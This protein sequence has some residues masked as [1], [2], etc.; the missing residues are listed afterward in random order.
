MRIAAL[1]GMA[2]D[3]SLAQSSSGG[4]GS[5]V[6]SLPKSW[7]TG[8]TLQDV[9][10]SLWFRRPRCVH[11]AD[12][13]GLL[14]CSQRSAHSARSTTSASPWPQEGSP[15][16]DSSIDTVPCPTGT[17]C[18]AGEGTF[19]PCTFWPVEALTRDGRTDPARLEDALVSCSGRCWA[20]PTT[21]ASTPRRRGP[22]ARPW[23]TSPGRSPTWPGSELP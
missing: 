10:T 12:A 11:A 14:H 1:V 23:R 15:P 4:R 8:G 5:A 22:A 6:R 20:T 9:R 16:I 19:K 2:V 7:K 3:R 17:A 18:P 21:W 13:V